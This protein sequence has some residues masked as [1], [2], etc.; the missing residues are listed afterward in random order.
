MKTTNQRFCPICRTW[1]APDVLCTDR[2]TELLRAVGIEPKPENEKELKE[3]IR[4]AD[5]SMLIILILI[6][7]AILL[8]VLFSELK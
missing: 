2:T 4:K 7:A 3:T 8:G 6:V 5:R 1:H